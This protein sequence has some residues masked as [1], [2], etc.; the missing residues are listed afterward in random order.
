MCVC[1]RKLLDLHVAMYMYSFHSC[2]GDDQLAVAYQLVL[3]N[4][5]ISKATGETR[6]IL[7]PR[8]G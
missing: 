3:D 7:M 6:P 1:E 5:A 2:R 4:R 8:L